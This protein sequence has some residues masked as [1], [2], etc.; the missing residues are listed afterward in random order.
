M[1]NLVSA[2]ENEN[3][4]EVRQLLSENKERINENG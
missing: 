2:V 4:D 3:V 1:A